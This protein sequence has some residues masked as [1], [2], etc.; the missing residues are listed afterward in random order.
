MTFTRASL[1]HATR[2]GRRGHAGSPRYAPQM[3]SRAILAL[4]ASV[5]ATLAITPAAWA[6][7]GEANVGVTASFDRRVIAPGQIAVATLALTNRGPDRA[8]AVSVDA[9]TDGARILRAAALPGRCTGSGGSTRCA[10]P[11]LGF[12]SFPG[13]TLTLAPNAGARR[14]AVAARVTSRSTRDPLERD[15]TTA[16]SIA[17]ARRSL[18]PSFAE[19]S[20]VFTSPRTAVGGKP[21]TAVLTLLNRGPASPALAGPVRVTP[22][23]AARVELSPVPHTLR[24]GE[25]RRVRV[26]VTPPRRGRLVI[27]IRVGTTGRAQVNVLVR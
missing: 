4:T 23:P 21:F 8:R 18:P 27:A 17:V 25:Q 26:R 2:A 15:D 12:G 1:A 10:F 20:F 11:V 16:S 13:I 19:V 24:V 7:D 14:I 5:F 6:P 22:S 9:R 3:P